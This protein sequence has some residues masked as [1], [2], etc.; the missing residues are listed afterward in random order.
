MSDFARLN[1]D[2]I[3]RQAIAAGTEALQSA[4]SEQGSA[5]LPLPTEREKPADMVAIVNKTAW[6][7]SALSGPSAKPK[8][9][10]LL[11]ASAKEAKV[12]DLSYQIFLTG[13]IKRLVD[14]FEGVD[15]AQID[16]SYDMA[17]K[18]NPKL[19]YCKYLEG[20]IGQ[21]VAKAKVKYDDMGSKKI[22]GVDS[23]LYGEIGQ[24]SG[25]NPPAGQEVEVIQPE[26]QAEINRHQA[27]E[28]PEKFETAEFQE[29]KKRFDPLH[30]FMLDKMGISPEEVSQMNVWYYVVAGMEEVVEEGN[31][32]L[33]NQRADCQSYHDLL[34]VR[35]RVPS[36]LLKRLDNIRWGEREYQKFEIFASKDFW[37][38]L[39]KKG[40][41]YS[42]YQDEF[43]GIFEKMK[44]EIE[45]D[46]YAEWVKMQAEV[47]APPAG[48]ET[49]A[50]VDLNNLSEAQL[51]ALESYPDVI[52]YKNVLQLE[53]T[54]K[55]A[56]KYGLNLDIFTE[57]LIVIEA[58]LAQ[59]DL[60]RKELIT[61]LIKEEMD[62]E[63]VTRYLK[64]K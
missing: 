58:F 62:P 59:W 54:T 15:M 43:F 33:Y 4:K 27:A 32:V 49:E 56:S 41:K 5:A 63:E 17:T 10:E 44:S 52:D 14:S 45:P 13:I 34:R 39:Q 22:T 18:A 19:N 35:S 1:L 47:T 16:R 29:Q 51:D 42:E 55:M 46:Q 37:E 50:Q 64:G 11:Q 25:V 48:Q 60:E 28:V 26:E 7:L 30:R 40:G 36:E 20:S 23:D 57:R 31:N 6:Q 21:I 2:E 38:E 53:E 3:E 8:V 12:D 24:E 61:D 9:M